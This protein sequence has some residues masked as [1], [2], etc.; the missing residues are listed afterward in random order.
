MT[1]AGLENAQNA[2]DE[3][4]KTGVFRSLTRGPSMRPMLRQQRDVVV[5]A[6]VKEP[7]KKYD[8]PMYRREGYDHLVLHRIL[9]VREDCYV[10]RG[11]NTYCLE[12]VPK[13][14]ILGVLQE[15]YRDG[16]RISCESRSYQRYVRWNIR[17]YPIR[18]LWH[19]GIRPKLGK[20]KRAL[21]KRL[22]R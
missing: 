8:V 3:M 22:K 7:L 19:R 1:P 11:D 16:K 20:I 13:E 21:L 14:Y 17:T 18:H 10:I 12:Y 9:Q 2:L 15:F 6:P 5:V 4:E